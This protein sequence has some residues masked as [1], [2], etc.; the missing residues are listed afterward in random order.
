[1]SSLSS[2]LERMG[3]QNDDELEL[4]V[5]DSVFT[6]A[7]VLCRG[8]ALGQLAACVRSSDLAALSATCSH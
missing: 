8:P 1:M 6:P 4:E 7:Q 3:L 5:Q 2:A